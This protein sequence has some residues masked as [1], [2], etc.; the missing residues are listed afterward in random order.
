MAEHR[1]FTGSQCLA[2]VGVSVLVMVSIALMRHYDQKAC[3][4]GKGLF[5]LRFRIAVHH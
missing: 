2:G 1:H 4:G 3:L 5:G